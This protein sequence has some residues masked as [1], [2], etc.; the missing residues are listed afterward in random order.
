MRSS[1]QLIGALGIIAGSVVAAN[2][3]PAI[4]NVDFRTPSNIVQVQGACGWGFYL[5]RWGDCIP[6]GYYRHHPRRA[7]PTRGRRLRR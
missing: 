7:R 6:I 2:A 1:L 4:P 3:A 5:S